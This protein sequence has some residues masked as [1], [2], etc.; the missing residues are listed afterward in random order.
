MS[1]SVI[2][3]EI[4]N[5]SDVM[6]GEPRV[7][8][9]RISVRQI[10]EAVE[11]RELSAETVA[12]MYDLDVATIYRALTYYHE[13]VEEMAAVRNHRQKLEEAARED[14]LTPEDI[15]E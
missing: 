8:G 9:H 2:T 12:R 15:D 7:E 1:E 14:A 4:V 10:A 3:P 13:N 5:T 6:G 11:G